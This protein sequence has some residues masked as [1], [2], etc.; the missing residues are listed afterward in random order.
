MRVV[1]LTE[2][3]EMRV[4]RH[5]LSQDDALGIHSTC[6]DWMDV[7]W[8]SPLNDNSYVFTPRDLV[9]QVPVTH[10]LYV[11][12]APKVPIAN[13]FR[14][15]EYAYD[16][17]SFAFLEGDITCGSLDDMFDRL[18]NVLAKRV[19]SRLRQGLYR[20]YIGAQDQLPYV[21]GRIE[22]MRSLRSSARGATTLACRYNEHTADLDDNRILAATLR[23]LPRAGLQREDVVR[24]VR[25][26]YRGMAGAVEASPVLPEDC[27]GR[28]YHRLNE[29]YRPMHGLCR[30]FLESCGP[31][32]NEGEK[33]FIPYSLRMSNLFELFVASWLRERLPRRYLIEP[34]CRAG[35]DE[36]GKTIFD[37]DLVLRDSA[38]GDVLAVLDTKYK[39]DA[40]A[41]SDDVQQIVAYA[42]TLRTTRAFLIYPSRN[43]RSEVYTA[44]DVHVRSLVFDVGEDPDESGLA[45]VN[46]LLDCVGQSRPRQS[47]H[48]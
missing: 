3:E 9:G 19:L 18:A 47:D 48:N 17:K 11:R 20:D 14:M 38:T 12:V 26:A 44:G 43:T 2:Y 6:G 21:R 39:R 35:Y 29:D 7:E 41:S 27:V 22:I 8:P 4:P 5:E 40:S 34:H 42:A 46:G 24:R 31:S 15:L 30:F 25:R 28:T 13:L 45:F 32:A 16:L 10:D 37:I 23:M 36:R 33:G 1:N